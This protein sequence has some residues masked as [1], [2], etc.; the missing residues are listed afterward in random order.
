MSHHAVLQR[1]QLPPFPPRHGSLWAHMPLVYQPS[2]KPWP[3]DLFAAARFFL[4]QCFQVPLL[5]T[6]HAWVPAQN[7]G[8]W[9]PPTAHRLARTWQETTSIS[10][11]IGSPCF[12]AT[13]RPGRVQVPHSGPWPRIQ[14]LSKLI[15]GHASPGPL[16]KAC[17]GSLIQT[18]SR[19]PCKSSRYYTEAILLLGENSRSLCSASLSL[20]TRTTQRQL[21]QQSLPTSF[22][23]CYGKWCNYITSRFK[24]PA[25]GVSTYLPETRL[26]C[27]VTNFTESA[28]PPQPL[29]SHLRF[30]LF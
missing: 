16:G 30:W 20:E 14:A 5:L 12:L 24:K 7:S 8:W 10:V 11:R 28:I 9:I 18:R 2:N 4:A 3:G 15:P 22:M 19:H 17:L 29:S 27:P 6:P 26:A 21:S 23:I 13:A 1:Q 25:N